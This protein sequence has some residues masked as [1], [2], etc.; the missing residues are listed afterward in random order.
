M[1]SAVTYEHLTRGARQFAWRGHDDASFPGLVWEASGRK[2]QP[3]VLCIHGLSGAAADFGPLARHLSAEGF[4]VWV[5]NLRG[6]GNDPDPR[7]RGH[8]LDPQEWRAD[9][10]AFAREFLADHPFHLVGESMGSLVAVD[11]VTHGALHPRRLV[12]SVPVTETRRPVPLWAIAMLRQ[13]GQWLPRCKFS[14]LRFVHG[15][16]SLPRLTSNDAYMHYL[17][18]IPHRVNGFT[19][20]FL[21]RFHDLM[22]GAQQSAGRLEIPTLMLSAGRDVFIRPDQSRAFFNRISAP[23]KEYVFY[24][25]SH[26]LL[27][28]DVDT[29]DV[30]A[31]ITRWI[32]EARP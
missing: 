23:E 15:K 29:D 7:R 13:A 4:T 5:I 21:T 26:H 12:L 31:R 24:P 19:I 10:A 22:E 25:E 11:A 8:F 20:D 32:T 27:W 30:L 1:V 14:P 17:K 28:H 6:Q 18:K 16:T 2:S 3:H 9:L